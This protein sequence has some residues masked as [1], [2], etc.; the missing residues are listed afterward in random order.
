MSGKAQF[1]TVGLLGAKIGGVLSTTGSSFDG[2]FVADRLEVGGSLFMRGG[3]RF[4]EVRL[5][6]AKVGGNLETDGSTFDDLFDAD[7]IEVARSCF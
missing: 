5:L 2:P 7:N 3:A 4:Q 1:Q 6:G